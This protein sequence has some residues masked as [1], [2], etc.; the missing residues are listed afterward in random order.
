[1]TTDDQKNIKE[2]IQKGSTIAGAA[3]G[4]AIGALVGGIPGAILGAGSGPVL[5]DLFTKVGSEIKQ[6][7]TGPREE[8]RVGAFLALVLHNTKQKTDSGARVREDDFF[9]ADETGRSP[10]DE[11]TENLILKA[12]REA[13]EKK[14]PLMAKLLSNIVLKPQFTPAIC[15]QLIKVSEQLTY[16]Q[17]C[18]LHIAAKKNQ[19]ITLRNKDYRSYGRFS[20]ELYTILNEIKDLDNRGFL[21]INPGHAALGL[22]DVVPSKMVVQTLGADLYHE[23]ELAKIPYA[24]IMDILRVLSTDT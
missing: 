14:I 24:D 3:T 12:Q 8:A 1:M 9:T 19:Y 2:L 10:A 15:H 18:I 16:R 4:G 17:L 22:T 20:K 13:E 7:V 5:T 21:D 23:M 11:V 6:R